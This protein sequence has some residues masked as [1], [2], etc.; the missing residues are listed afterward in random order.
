[1]TLFHL[2]KI[3][4]L[5][6]ISMQTIDTLSCRANFKTVLVCNNFAINSAVSLSGR[7]GLEG[8]FAVH[9]YYIYYQEGFFQGP[10]NVP[11]SR[12]KALNNI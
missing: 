8:S 3:L 12:G 4:N 9:I 1:M 2:T 11:D 10:A 7:E 6:P 5:Q